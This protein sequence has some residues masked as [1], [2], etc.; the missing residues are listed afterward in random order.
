MAA[1][2]ANAIKGLIEGAGLGLAAYRDSAPWDEAMP[3]VTISEGIS[4]TQDIRGEGDGLAVSAVIELIQIDVWER[5]KDEDENLVE[6]PDLALRVQRALHG[7]RLETAPMRVYRLAAP[8][9]RRLLELSNNVV[10]NAITA[11]VQRVL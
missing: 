1:S 8:N 9:R 2:L 10:H 7:A 4:V 11:S 3:Y 5:W 6:S